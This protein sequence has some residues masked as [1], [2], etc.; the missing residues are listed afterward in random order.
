MQIAEDPTFCTLR[1]PFRLQNTFFI[2]RLSDD[3]SDESSKAPTKA[4]KGKGSSDISRF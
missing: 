4:R 2:F 3:V 1:E